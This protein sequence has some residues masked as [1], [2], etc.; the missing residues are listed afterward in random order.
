MLTKCKFFDYVQFGRKNTYEISNTE[1][2]KF[3]HVTANLN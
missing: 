2:R 3:Q 1:Q